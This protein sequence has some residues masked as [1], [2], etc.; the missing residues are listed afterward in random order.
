MRGS[1]MRRTRS[2][3][4]EH[5][6]EWEEG[7]LRPCELLH[8]FSAPLPLQGTWDEGVQAAVEKWHGRMHGACVSNCHSFVADCL[9]EMRYAGIERGYFPFGVG[10]D[11]SCDIYIYMY[12]CVYMYTCIFV[13]LT[14]FLSGRHFL[15]PTK[16]HSWIC[17]DGA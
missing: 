2:K 17:L 9:H 8:A 16:R 14:Y 7:T 4:G 1:R 5:K 11:A 6:E 15:C 13:M 10:E 12:I 3:D